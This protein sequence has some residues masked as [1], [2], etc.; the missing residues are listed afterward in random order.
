[1]LLSSSKV[2]DFSNDWIP[3]KRESKTEKN[4]SFPGPITQT[5][6]KTTQMNN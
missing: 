4:G 5:T 1:M 3:W 6:I 2:E